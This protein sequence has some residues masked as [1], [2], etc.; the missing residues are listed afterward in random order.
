MKRCIINFAKDGRENYSLGRERLLDSITEIEETAD[1]LFYTEYPKGCPTHQE[2]SVVFKAYMFREAFNKGYD[3]VLWLDAS[4]V[5]LKDLEYIW[6][7]IEKD[8]YFFVNNPNQIQVMWASE[9]QLKTM[10]C[11]VE[12]A[13]KFEM[14]R[15][16]MMG[17]SK[18]NEHLIDWM[19]KLSKEDNGI[20]FN[21][22]N[23]S[24]SPLF[25]DPRHDQ[26]VVSWIIHRD[27][28]YKH[29]HLLARY[30]NEEDLGI[31]FVEFRGM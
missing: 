24:S 21:G 2:V 3:S 12:E 19:I 26:A 4:V 16:G 28:L 9:K 31:A 27:R 14:C 5:V 1:Q 18:E 13:E 10:G 11:T 6:A 7:T 15:A 23:H 8:G 29:S 22:D 30:T 17:L 25:K 20:A